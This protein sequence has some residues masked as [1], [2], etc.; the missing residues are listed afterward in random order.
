MDDE[1]ELRELNLSTRPRR[2]ERRRYRER[3]RL[4]RELQRWATGRGKSS[5]VLRG[6]K[7]DEGGG[8]GGCMEQEVKGVVKS[9]ELGVGWVLGSVSQNRQGGDRSRRLTRVRG[10]C[11]DGLDAL[12]NTANTLTSGPTKLL[13][14]LWS[15]RQWC[16]CWSAHTPPQCCDASRQRLGVP[17]FMQGA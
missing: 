17:C 4:E 14:E 8:N 10:H 5:I 16:V 6:E 3:G 12:T 2:E 7:G 15:C 11:I 1:D 13:C 9:G